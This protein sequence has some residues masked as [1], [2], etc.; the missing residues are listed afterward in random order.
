MSCVTSEIAI[1]RNARPYRDAGAKRALISIFLSDA[2]ALIFAIVL[3]GVMANLI[4]EPL[5][6]QQ[7]ALT[8]PKFLSQ[9]Y[10]S[11][12]LGGVLLIWF[13]AKKHYHARLTFSTQTKDI[14]IGC[15]A[16]LCASA[17]ISFAAK[18]DPSRLAVVLTWALAGLL[19]TVGR[20]VTKAS[21]L[22]SGSWFT[23]VCLLGAESRKEKIDSIARLHPELGFAVISWFEISTLAERL[24]GLSDL[25]RQTVMT[26]IMD[27]YGAKK[28]VIAP[29][30]AEYEASIALIEVLQ[31]LRI[32]FSFAPDTGALSTN[33]IILHALSPLDG[34]MMEPA[35]NIERPLARAIKNI[36]EPALAGLALIF[37]APLF[38]VIAIAVRSDGGPIF[39][40]QTRIGLGGRQFACFKFRSMA[41]DA[42][43]R[44]ERLLAADADAAAEW[45]RDQKL[46]NDPRITTIGRVLRKTS[47]DELPQLLN[48]L[49]GDMSI[50]GPRPVI[51]GEIDRYGERASYYFR[52]KPG[53]TGLWQ[54]NGRNNTTY[55]ERVRL[56]AHYVRNWTLWRDFCIACKTV[57]E[58]IWRR[59]GV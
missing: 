4:R 38:L 10:Q 55:A 50:V 35:D 25:Q 1:S 41:T 6:L 57:P 39:F 23:P 47:L 7:R 44:L 22:K 13:A 54:V 36:A 32:P 9:A 59:S 51:P 31:R 24:E 5:D 3:A 53:L 17:V 49:A 56:D 18:T 46:R 14:L 33:N 16:A 40:R 30:P 27:L 28:F 19:T 48:V 15:G 45:E 43:E 26:E 42:Q 12:A 20:H 8:D 34:L 29:S 2:A 58:L 21:L 52:V 37:F 11:L